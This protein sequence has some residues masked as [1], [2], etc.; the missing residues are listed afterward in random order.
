MYLINH[1]I[2]ETLTTGWMLSLYWW[3][4]CCGKVFNALVW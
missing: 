3:Y 2:A 1:G 4:Y